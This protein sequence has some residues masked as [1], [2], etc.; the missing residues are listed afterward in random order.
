MDK[1]MFRAQMIRLRDRI[2]VTQIEMA[3][4][5]GIERTEVQNYE[6]GKKYPSKTTQARIDELMMKYPA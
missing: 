2:G 4:L 3:R 5:L 1:P 6:Y